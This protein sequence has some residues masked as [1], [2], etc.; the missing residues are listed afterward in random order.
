M[1]QRT[2]TV[3]LSYADAE[4]GLWTTNEEARWRDF[5]F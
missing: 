4:I 2:S 3:E 1:M 5:S